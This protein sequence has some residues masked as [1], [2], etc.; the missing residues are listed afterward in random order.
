MVGIMAMVAAAMAAGCDDDELAT[1]Q[2]AAVADALSAA[3]H[4][5]GAEAGMEASV[6]VNADV[7]AGVEALVAVD[8]L[9]AADLA[10]APSCDSP[11][12]PAML[13]PGRLQLWLRSDVG[14]DCAAEGTPRRVTAWRDQSGNGRDARAA[15]GKVGPAC[16]TGA[17]LNGREVVSFPATS[18][19][20][21]EEHLEMEL[22]M[23]AGKPFSIAVVEQRAEAR[24]ASFFLGS[25]LPYP[26]AISCNNNINAGKGLLLG[27]P[28]AVLMAASTWGP[29][30]DI[31]V[32]VAPAPAKPTRTLMVFTPGAG[33]TLQVDGVTIGE[34]RSNG[35][36]T[37]KQALLG[38]GYDLSTAAMDS[39]YHGVIAEV[40]VF[41]VALDEGQRAALDGYLRARWETGP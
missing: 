35:L 34:S 16:S 41:D 9:T 15:A 22:G 28:I 25:R 20:D 7:Q 14:V 12:C 37:M 2:P 40:A 23:L 26:D 18:G 32:P 21:G 27:Y 39:R 6:E 31:N 11:G 3:G 13:A 38:R 5:A 1:A 36:L 4:D 10:T 29:D 8:A 19:F 24:I 17:L 30:C 33:L